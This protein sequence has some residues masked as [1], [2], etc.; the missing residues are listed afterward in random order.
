MDNQAV[1]WEIRWAPLRAWALKQNLKNSFKL[2][3][4]DA[5]DDDHFLLEA[6]YLALVD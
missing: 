3:P 1:L 5:T 6:S 4:L 2:H